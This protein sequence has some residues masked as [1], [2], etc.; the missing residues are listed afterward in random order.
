MNKNLKTKLQLTAIGYVFALLNSYLAIN[1]RP[2]EGI[3]FGIVACCFFLKSLITK[4][5]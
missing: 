1:G 4:D 5:S 3:F 2:L